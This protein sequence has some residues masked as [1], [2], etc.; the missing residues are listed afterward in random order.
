MKTIYIFLFSILLITLSSCSTDDA[1]V[2]DADDASQGELRPSRPNDVCFDWAK[3]TIGID[4][5]NGL[6][7]PILNFGMEVS[8]GFINPEKTYEVKLYLQPIADCEDMNS[9]IGSPT[10]ITLPYTITNP[11]NIPD[12]VVYPSQL[13]S[14]C[15]KWKAVIST[16]AGY[17]YYCSSSTLW[18][19]APLY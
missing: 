12:F 16:S 6:N 15:Y 17:P 8:V 7:N 2:F 9:D 14:A 19:D 10:I 4:Y 1:V 11:S 13:P 18:Y 3:G 5:T